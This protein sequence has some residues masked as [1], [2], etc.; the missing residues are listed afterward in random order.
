MPTRCPVPSCGGHIVREEG[1]AAFRC[2]NAAC[3][4]QLKS[5]IRHFASRNALDIDGL[6]EKLV[7]QLVEKGLVRDLADL[8]RLREDDLAA[9][10]RMGEK[11]AANL[12]AQLERSKERTLPH[13]LVALG[14]RQVGEATA[15]ALAEHFGTLERIMDASEEELQE[16]RDIGPEV[17]QSIRRFFAERQN[18]R[19][20]Q[21]LLAAGVRPAPVERAKGPLV[22]KK[23]VLTGAL[24]TMTRPEAQRR[25]EARGGR[26]VGSVSKETDYVVVGAEPGSKLA[27]AKALGVAI[28]DEDALLHLIGG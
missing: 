23:F 25:I 19:V 24:A 26:V 10:E 8:Y 7:D 9:L 21:R 2:I 4:A 13:L 11:S 15:K 14:I 6:G 5:R 20:V 17:A 1:E 3:P 22:G 18:R 16:V 27:K 28:V 12:R